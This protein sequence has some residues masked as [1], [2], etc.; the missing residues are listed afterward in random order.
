MKYKENEGEK[1]NNQQQ[2]E[3]IKM[4]PRALEIKFYFLVRKT[5][6]YTKIGLK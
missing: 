5:V 4:N 1:S 2:K 3:M 6:I